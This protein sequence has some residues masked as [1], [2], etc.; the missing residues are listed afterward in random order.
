LRVAI[1]AMM[2]SAVIDLKM[3]DSSEMVFEL[4]F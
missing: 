2:P 4:K 3:I 1:Q